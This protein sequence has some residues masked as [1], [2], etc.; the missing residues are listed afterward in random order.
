MKFFFYPTESREAEERSFR[1]GQLHVTEAVPVSKVGVSE[2]N[3]NSSLHIDPYLGTYY[4]QLNTRK[5]PLS[6]PRV[7]R[8]L[9]LAINRSM[10]VDQITQ[11]RQ[12]P[13]WHFTPPGTGGY[14]P[15]I[16]AERNIAQAKNSSAMQVSQKEM[17][18]QNSL[19]STIL[20]EIIKPL[21]LLYNKCGKHHSTF[22][23]KSSIKN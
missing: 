2:K 19:I 22:M 17:D 9:S 6:D 7:R 12:Q 3:N 14:D 10:I 20:Q 4:L 1:A 23:S 15:G 5:P 16:S 11:G 21:Q 13:A 18:F 8:A